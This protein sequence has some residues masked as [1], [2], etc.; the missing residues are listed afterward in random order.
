MMNNKFLYLLLTSAM[1]CYACS[2]DENPPDG[3]VTASYQTA[4][5][6]Q[7]DQLDIYT[8]NSV[9]SD[10]SFISGFLGRY[11]SSDV[12]KLFYVNQTVVNNFDNQSSLDF[13]EGN[14]VSFGRKMME[15]IEK[16][17]TLM[18]IAEMDST[19]VPV[20]DATSSYAHMLGLV[21]A[22]TPQRNCP[23]GTCT[24]YRKTYPIIIAG[25]DYYLP[26]LYVLVF[27]TRK[28]QFMGLPVVTTN[29]KVD[30]ELPMLNTIRADLRSTLAEKLSAGDSILVQSGRLPLIKR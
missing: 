7:V 4:N 15:I 12:T 22:I 28:E 25:K 14:K 6:F 27:N 24:K 8:Q 2:K 1:F 5:P 29:W 18:L 17:D 26:Y 30:G 13:L 9:I 19:A 10:P 11:I 3:P 21:P 23:S 20:I 16:N